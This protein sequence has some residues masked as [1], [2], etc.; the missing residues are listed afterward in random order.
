MRV[1]QATLYLKWWLSSTD[2]AASTLLDSEHWATLK[3]LYKNLGKIEGLSFRL[4]CYC[5]FSGGLVTMTHY[6]NILTHLSAQCKLRANK[7]S[8]T[9]K[10]SILWYLRGSRSPCWIHTDTKMGTAKVPIAAPEHQMKSYAFNKMQPSPP[11][12][13][14][15]RTHSPL[16]ET[17]GVLHRLPLPP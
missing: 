8:E 6:G 2:K 16:S 5:V 14:Q 17:G 13:S 10:Q 1:V 4:S 7:W 11:Q 3:T 12:K 9:R 15:F